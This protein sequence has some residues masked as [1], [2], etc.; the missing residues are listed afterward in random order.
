MTCKNAL[1]VFEEIPSRRAPEGSKELEANIGL[2]NWNRSAYK[3]LLLRL[4]GGAI[5]GVFF[6]EFVRYAPDFAKLITLLV[7]IVIIWYD[8]DF[9]KRTTKSYVTLRFWL[10]IVLGLFCGVVWKITGEDV[11]VR[12]GIVCICLR[13]VDRVIDWAGARR[14]L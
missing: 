7:A 9:P 14:T 4:L 1:V 6:Y 13:A 12:L 8:P 3:N 10:P 2:S 11:W 5:A